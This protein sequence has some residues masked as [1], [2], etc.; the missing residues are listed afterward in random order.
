M[1]ILLVNAPIPR[2]IRMF[3]FADE[4]T[5]KSF[6]R[7][8]MVGPPLALNEISAM[9]PDEEVV[10]LDQKTEFDNI[11]D[12]DYEKEYINELI[13]F[14]P[15]IVGFTCITAQYNSV[16][17]LIDITKKHDR[18]ILTFVGG[19]HPTLCSESFKDTNVDVVCIG[20]GKHSYKA[21]VDEYK[22]NGRNADFSKI[23]GVAIN[24]NHVLRY[25]KSICELTMEEV[26]NS[27]LNEDVMPNRKLTD[28]YNY[29]I[30]H[31]NKTIH[32]ISTSQGC[33][34][35]CNFCTVWQTTGGEY[36]HKDVEKIIKELKTM[37]KYE[38]IRFCD[39]NT[40][41]DIKKAKQLFTRI[42]EEGLDKHFYMA[43]VRVDTV[44]SHP[45]VL[46][47]ARDAGLR[48]VICGLEG[49]SDEELKAYNKQSTI[50][51]TKKALKYLNELGIFVNGN[52][53]VKPNFVESDFKQLEDFVMENPIFNSGFTVL[54][55]FP[56]TSLWEEMKDDILNENLDYYNLTNSVVK[57]TLPEEVFYK[58]MCKLYK[59]SKKS[60]EKY[61][62][63]YGHLSAM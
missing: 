12:Y 1:K 34:H 54:T 9:T 41:G 38:I 7:R 44:I 19:I 31:V 10:I 3:D 4:E 20:I 26:R 13:R 63:L 61:I 6:G 8:V 29:K 28:K 25:T 37:D 60:A 59:I 21:I 18:D 24:E 40:F 52:Y 49:T 11:K 42:I 30:N 33:T 32:Y 57:T 55:P 16:L 47:L 39:A 15:D 35:K 22:K 17:N 5:L 43:D 58:R 56:G 48:I 50:D 53:I 14:K 62:K 46:K 36:Y 2:A 45:D 51:K 23:T 27:H